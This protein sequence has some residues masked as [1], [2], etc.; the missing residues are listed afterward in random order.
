M[1]VGFV[2]HTVTDNYRLDATLV[3]TGRKRGATGNGRG[4]R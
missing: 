3:V 1:D 4:L 2:G